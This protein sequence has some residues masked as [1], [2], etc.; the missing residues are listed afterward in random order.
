[1]EQAAWADVDFNPGV[2]ESGVAAR[3]IAVADT[4][5]GAEAA[6]V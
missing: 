3:L 4:A 5:E 6:D 2:I 1:M